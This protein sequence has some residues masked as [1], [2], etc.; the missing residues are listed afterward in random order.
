M[1]FSECKYETCRKTAAFG[2]SGEK[3]QYCSKHKQPNMINLSVRR[4]TK[5]SNPAY[6]GYTGK[7]PIS[8]SLHWSKG[9]L[10]HPTK[11]CVTCKKPAT[12][13]NA[14]SKYYCGDHKPV[15]CISEVERIENYID[16]FDKYAD[17]RDY[18]PGTAWYN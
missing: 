2:L 3:R 13:N 1:L 7:I 5:C 15:D 11:K 14:R 18:L 4:C 8:C 6:Y 17:L 12:H 10:K 16:L 9:M